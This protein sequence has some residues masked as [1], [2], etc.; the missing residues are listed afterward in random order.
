MN[1]LM[2]GMKGKSGTCRVADSIY[3]YMTTFIHIYSTIIH[4]YP[5]G[6]VSN[7][8]GEFGLAFWLPPYD[9]DEQE[10][11]CEDDSERYDVPHS[12]APL[13]R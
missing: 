12:N 6:S 13:H 7:L 4:I 9:E 11:D 5:E 10:T 1:M 8:E 3:I 2:T